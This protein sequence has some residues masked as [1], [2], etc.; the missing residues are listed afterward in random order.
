MALL[1]THDSSIIIHDRKMRICLSMEGFS[2]FVIVYALNQERLKE[3][4]FVYPKA[5]CKIMEEYQN[6]KSVN[7]WKSVSK[8]IYWNRFIFI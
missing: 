6:I 7:F 2:K 1:T 4:S 5:S 8:S 3:T